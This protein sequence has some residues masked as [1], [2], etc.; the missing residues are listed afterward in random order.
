MIEKD[1]KNMEVHRK[2]PHS[3][4]R[5]KSQLEKGVAECANR[6]FIIAIDIIDGP[7]IIIILI[8]FKFKQE[9]NPNITYNLYFLKS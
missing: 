5:P 8:K 2:D 9:Q 7:G 1:V 4:R 3:T 6:R